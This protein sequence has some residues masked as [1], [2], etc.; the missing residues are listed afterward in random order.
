MP[1]RHEQ[2]GDIGI[3]ISCGGLTVNPGDYIY[4]DADGVV[5]VPSHVHD[6]V[7]Q[8]LSRL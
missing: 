2:L 5:V 7:A 1:P 8:L 6:E 3:P 4:A